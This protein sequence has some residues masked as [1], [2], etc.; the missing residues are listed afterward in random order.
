MASRT[1]LD[2]SEP[3]V[4]WSNA[5]VVL[6]EQDQWRRRLEAQPGRFFVRELPGALREAADELGVAW[7]EPTGP[8]IAFLG[9]ATTACNAVLR[10]LLLKPSD[11]ILVF[12]HGYGALHK[13]VRFV[14]E[15]AAGLMT[16]ATLPFPHPDINTIVASVAA[17]L[18]QRTKLAVIDHI[19]VAERP[20]F[21][22]RAHRVSLPR[23]KC[24]SLGGWS[25]RARAGAVKFTSYGG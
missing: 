14:T 9:N 7:S 18:T 4:L 13:A 19:T 25:A 21:A 5:S 2:L 10:Y 6:A 17:A 11:E 20:R 23:G 22:S 3:R 12:T 16:E 15:R 24:A 1:E 8:T